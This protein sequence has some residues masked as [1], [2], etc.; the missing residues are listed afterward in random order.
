MNRIDSGKQVLR[1]AE[2]SL[3]RLLADA[4]INGDYAALPVLAE[5]AQRVASLLDLDVAAEES[6]EKPVWSAPRTTKPT[7]KPS[8]KKRSAG[9]PKF[10]KDDDNLVKIGWS[11]RDGSEYEHKARKEVVRAVVTSISLAGR[12]GKRFTMETI[13]PLKNLDGSSIPDYQ[14]YLVLAWL[15]SIELVTQHGRLGYT[16]PQDID[17]ADVVE[18]CWAR[19]ADRSPNETSPIR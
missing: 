3:Q 9:Y 17:L 5:W 15:R 14:A 7:K 8:R 10:V 11:K 16:V 12:R 4:A 2:Q 18:D 6:L 19:L 1:E 13:L